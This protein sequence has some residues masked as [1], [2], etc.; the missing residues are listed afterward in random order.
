MKAGEAGRK[1]EATALPPATGTAPGEAASWPRSR[2]AL[3]LLDF[4]QLYRLP[5]SI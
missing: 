3:Q 5:Q 2:N 1:F 4:D